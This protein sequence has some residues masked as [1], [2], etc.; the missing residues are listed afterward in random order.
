[1]KIKNWLYI[2]VGLNCVAICFFLWS[3]TQAP[4]TSSVIAVTNRVIQSAAT[5]LPKKNVTD[6]SSQTDWIQALH[7]AGF[8]KQRIGEIAA[9]DFESRW[10]QRMTDAQRRFDRGE[11]G[12]NALA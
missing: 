9:A 1:M 11:I 10:Q 12:D 5:S 7:D 2:S 3:P 4:K 6:A 8:S